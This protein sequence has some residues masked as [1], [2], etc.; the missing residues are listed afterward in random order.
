M[1]DNHNVN[2][3]LTSIH[4][5]VLAQL[6]V[7]TDN[8]GTIT[9]STVT[10][11]E[12]LNADLLTSLAPLTDGTQE[13]KIVD[14]MGNTLYPVGKPA[15]LVTEITRPANTTGYDIGD[16]I[17]T[18]AA[19]VKQKEIVTVT[20]SAPVK[21]KYTLTLSGTSGTAVISEAGTLTKT[22][23]F[24]GTLDQTAND[25][26]IANAAFYNVEGITLTQSTNTLIFESEV[27]GTTIVAPVITTATGDLSGTVVET[28]PNTVVGQM[29]ISIMNVGTGTVS[30]TTDINGTVAAFVVDNAAAFLPSIEVTGVNDTIVFEATVAGV[31]FAVPII[32]TLV[33]DLS[34]TNTP[35]TANATLVP[36]EF[37][38]VALT[39]DGGGYIMD[40]KIQTN[41]VA[42][43]GKT[44]RLW[45][46]DLAPT[47]ML[48]DNVGYQTPYADNYKILFFVDVVMESALA[49]SDAVV[50]QASVIKQYNSLT[51]NKLFGVLQTQSAFTPTS[52]GKFSIMLNILKVS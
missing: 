21:Q 22:I 51:G 5:D 42:A 39:D 4:R 34:G 24:N 23:T 1:A 35:T 2:A 26:Y 25:F 46:Y 15:K 11:I 38:N 36:L 41:I 3:R 20:G 30:Y 50:G 9:N 6:G 49:G 43:A 18:Y 52:G 44:L 17:T 14:S 37:A 40:V 29:S 28:T 10:A 19:N 45:I 12:D 31:P 32:T 33:G 13:T 27:A 47:T 8:S 16:V 48:G 7:T